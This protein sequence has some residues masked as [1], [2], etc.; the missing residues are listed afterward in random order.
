VKSS[1][2][3]EEIRGLQSHSQMRVTIMVGLRRVVLHQSLGNGGHSQL[4]EDPD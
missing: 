2:L 1:Q 4:Y 3:K